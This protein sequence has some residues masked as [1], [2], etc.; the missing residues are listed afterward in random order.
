MRNAN[1]A[2]FS[3]R[4]HEHFICPTNGLET[5]HSGAI[6]NTIGDAL[7]ETGLFRA[8]GHTKFIA[9]TLVAS[10]IVGSA[11]ITIGLFETGW[12]TSA[13]GCGPD[14]SVLWALAL[15][16]VDHRILY[17]NGVAS[18]DDHQLLRY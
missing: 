4:G 12:F 11:Q 16:S 8:G 18:P 9:G 13:R 2:T 14:V 6:W 17:R 10:V 3:R 5:I 1:R 15:F 7:G